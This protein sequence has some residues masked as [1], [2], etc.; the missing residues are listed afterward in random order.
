MDV[1]AFL[2]PDGEDDVFESISNAELVS[3]VVAEDD[4]SS[5]VENE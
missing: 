2:S 1:S 5:R 4:D 3:K